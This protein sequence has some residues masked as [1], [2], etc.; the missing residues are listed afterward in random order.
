MNKKII[1]FF[2]AVSII[3]GIML[4][5]G[6]EFLYNKLETKDHDNISERGSSYFDVLPSERDSFLEP[7]NKTDTK[8]FKKDLSKVPQNQNTHKV[9]TKDEITNETPKETVGGKRSKKIKRKVKGKSKRKGKGERKNKFRTL[10][11]V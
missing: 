11:K 6:G 8:L 1:G 5:S 9:L 7:P 3:G 4:F 2:V 10:K